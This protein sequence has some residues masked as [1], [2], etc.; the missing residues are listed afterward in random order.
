MNVAA[1][2]EK[3]ILTI[4]DG[5]LFRYDQLSIG[6]GSY[7]TAA[8]ALERLSKKGTIRKQARGIFYKPRQTAFGEM[9]PDEYQL[10]EPYLFDNG[11]RI[12]YI[13]GSYLYRQMGLTTQ[14]SRVVKIAIRDKR[15]TVQAGAIKALPVKSY[16]EVTDANYTLLGLLDAF[17]DLNS[18]P[19]VDKSAAIRI[20]QTYIEKLSTKE[21]AMLLQLA[22]Q[23]PPRVRA[24]LGAVTENT[25][26]QKDM[27]RLKE[28]LNPFSAYRYDLQK[29]IL[30]NLENWNIR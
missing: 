20:L 8:K 10:L 17:K 19:D 27:V 6:Q 18:I 25:L 23:Y 3:Q 24:L 2:I 22:L 11:K 16:V 14:L 26:S 9:K 1:N 15:I 28:S 5:V 12:A 30:D 13:T 4:P 29:G 7:A 21:K